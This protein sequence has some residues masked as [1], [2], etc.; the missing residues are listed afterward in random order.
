MARSFLVITQDHWQPKNKLEVAFK[1]Y[2]KSKNQ[3][4]FESKFKEKLFLK[5]VE[6][7]VLELNKEFSRCTPLKFETIQKS[8]N[9]VCYGCYRF[10]HF[11]IYKENEEN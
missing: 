9:S 4:I 5:Q 3:R 11:E 1:E 7:K 2:I 6:H 10:L 8:K